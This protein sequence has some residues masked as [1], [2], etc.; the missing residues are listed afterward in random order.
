MRRNYFILIISL[1]P[2]ITFFSCKQK[3]V[4]TIDKTAVEKAYLSSDTTKGSLKIDIDVEIPVCYDNAAIL[5]SI[6]KDV[7][8]NLFGPE[9]TGF[10]EDSIVQ[11]FI[12]DLIREYRL[13][14]QPI[15]A[16]M[17][18]TNF[19]S[20]NNEHHLEGFSVLTD[21]NIFSYGI[22]RYVF[23]GGAHGLSNLTYLNYNLK[24]GKKITEADIFKPGYEKDLSD[25][26]KSRIVEQSKEDDSVQN[27]EKL[28]DT[29]YWVDE[30]KPNGNFYLSDEGI[31][32]V[33]N[34]YEIAPYYMGQTEVNIPYSRIAYLLE[35]VSVISYLASKAISTK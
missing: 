33:F 24:T 12:K 17:D 8:T 34:P 30:I 32:Y 18:S 2:I 21:E 3:T 4:R 6:K 13:T 1:L 15:L 29:D 7:I 5:D 28:E 25:I 22:N 16:Q 26:I 10:G 9:Y 23:M 19:Y 27:I 20:F 35:P 11:V 14:N 31:N